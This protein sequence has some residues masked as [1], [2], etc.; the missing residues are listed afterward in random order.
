MHGLRSLTVA[1]LAVAGLMAALPALAQ[2]KL[3]VGYVVVPIQLGPLIFANDKLT[4]H[5][6]KSYTV[7]FIH[8][9]GSAPQLT[10]LVA[11]EL[12]IAALAF[13][14]FAA[15]IVNA[16]QDLVALADI[17][18]DG[19]SFSTV[20]GVLADSP[21]QTIPDLKG[22]VLAINAKGGAVDM[23]ARI[24]LLQHGLKPGLDVTFIEA[25]FGAMEAMLRQRKTDV[26][27]FVAPFW[28]AAQRK[29]GIRPLFYQRDGL[30]TTQFLLYVA[31]REYVAQHR[32]V[33]VDWLE[34]YVRGTRWFLDP[35]N[36]EEALALT[37]AFTKRPP[38]AY[39]DWAFLPGKDYYH[40]PDGRLDLQ[41][42]QRN[43]D[44][45]QELGIL[46][47]SFPVADHT[48]AS[49]LEA[50]LAQLR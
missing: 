6:G 41:A 26:A 13:S 3:R 21:I 44:A 27:T 39:A 9:R 2:P 38:S 37:A 11:G 30:G 48:D 40:D 28:A 35:A 4:V 46:R 29:G 31:R 47:R 19:P 24:V 7:E 10:A 5:K 8:F 49:L 23:A 20:Y 1:V 32:Q 43:I 36:R 12:E 16:R 14:T 25:Q 33:L 18:R 50:A 22:K 45:L 42:L 17:A 34:D 15:G